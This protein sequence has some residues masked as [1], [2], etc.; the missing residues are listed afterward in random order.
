M[1]HLYYHQWNKSHI[2]FRYMIPLHISRCCI[3]ERNCSSSLKRKIPQQN[4]A[5]K[6]WCVCGWFTLDKEKKGVMKQSQKLSQIVGRLWHKLMFSNHLYKNRQIYKL[7]QK[8][9]SCYY[10]NGYQQLLYSTDKAQRD[11]K[12]SDGYLLWH[13]KYMYIAL[14][15]I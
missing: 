7:Q 11:K 8:L 5:I 10:K 13:C 12:L 3:Q 2:L 15:E 14:H 4:K 6:L 1:I 9:D